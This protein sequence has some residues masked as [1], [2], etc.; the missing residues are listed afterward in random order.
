MGDK[1]NTPTTRE[2]I[3]ETWLTRDDVREAG[4]LLD[5]AGGDGSYYADT[6][7]GYEGRLTE[8]IEWLIKQAREEDARKVTK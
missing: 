6:V 1:V 3:R 4:I 7:W 2:Q 8:E 5:N